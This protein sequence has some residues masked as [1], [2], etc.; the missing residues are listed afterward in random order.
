VNARR[1]PNQAQDPNKVATIGPDG[2][3]MPSNTFITN[4]DSN[5]QPKTLESAKPPV[6]RS[7]AFQKMQEKKDMR[8]A[9]IKEAREKN[10]PI[11]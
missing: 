11:M 8:D 5:G 2:Q 9:Q 10:N 4:V 1:N 3:E 7:E 6:E